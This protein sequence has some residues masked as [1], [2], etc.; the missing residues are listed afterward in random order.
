MISVIIPTLDAAERVGPCLAAV[1]AGIAT[2]G[3]RDVVIADGGSS[4]NMRA[5]AEEVGADF[6]EAPRGRGSQLRAGAAAAKG[7][8]L[9]FLHAD[10]VLPERWP[11]LALAH[12]AAAP[13]RAAVFRLRFDAE[14]LGPRVVASWADL[15]TRAFAL[16]YG[17]QALLISRR[18]YDSVD[19]HP[20][21]PLMEDVAIARRLGRGR[22]TRLDA[23]VTTS[24]EAYERSGWMRR[25]ARNLS[26]LALYMLGATPERL[27]ERYR[28]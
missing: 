7:E 17:D 23:A 1:A 21:I 22:L 26:T 6:I 25:G 14:G 27:A 16:P 11:D 4:D 24:F 2:P 15:R 28:R 12:I 5:I 9:L 10:T 19:G 8:W 3:L 20:P 18:L 13:E